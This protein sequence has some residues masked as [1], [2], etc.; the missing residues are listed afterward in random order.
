MRNSTICDNRQQT[1][2]HSL[3]DWNISSYVSLRYPY[4]VFSTVSHTPR[5]NA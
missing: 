1:L 4:L 3:I 5:T 2:T